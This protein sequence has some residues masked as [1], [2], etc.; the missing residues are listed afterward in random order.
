VYDA[1]DLFTETHSLVGRER[2]RRIWSF[3]ERR[4]I[5]FAARV[6]TVSE[7]IA[8]ELARRYDIAA[9][10]VLRN[11][12]VYRTPP[13][14]RFFF[15]EAPD[16]P[17]LLCQGYL[18]KG[19]GLEVLVGA[20]RHVPRGRLVLLGDGEM[21]EELDRLVR[22]LRLEKKVTLRPAVPIDE[23]PAWTTSATL[24]FLLYST[25]SLNFLYALPN[26]FFEYVMAGVPVVSSPIPEVAELIVAH[27]VGSVVERV[28]PEEVAR[29]INRLLADGEGI[30]RMKG[31]CLRAARSLHWGIEEAK[32]LGL[33]A[34]L[35][36]AS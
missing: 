26:K 13:E 28:T 3:L 20:M 21:R 5:R 14:P 35:T 12:P 1:H 33:Y 32:L 6:I 30:A 9:P 19:R 4:L 7:S 25:A 18:Q 16:E 24:G 27:G 11:C 29:E 23:L 34:G 36:R 31:N 15:P 17:V 2:E 22:I 8:R 10:L